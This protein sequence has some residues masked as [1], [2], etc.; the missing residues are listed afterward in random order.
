MF[1]CRSRAASLLWT[2]LLSGHC[3]ASIRLARYQTGTLV[4]RF[5]WSSGLI[6]RG[7]KNSMLKTPKPVFALLLLLVFAF[8]SAS[9]QDW[10]HTGT[11]RGAPIKLAVPD[12]K[13]AS[14]DPQT[15]P[16][17]TVFNQTL[18]NDL[19][20]SGVFEMVS[21]SFYPLQTPGTPGELKVETWGNAPVDAAMVAFGNLGVANGKVN[22]QGWLFDAKNAGAPQ[23]LGKQYQEN[24][25]PDYAR[26]IAHKFADEIIFRLGGGINGIAES[27]LYFISSRSGHKEVWQMDYDGAAQSQLTHLSSI[28][29]LSP[30]VSPDNTR[31][32]FSSFAKR[33]LELMMYSIELGRIVSFPTYNGTNISP[34]WAPDGSKIAFSS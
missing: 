7:R 13:A 9:A 26:L 3:S 20:N 2:S 12:F 27:K 11:N 15:A 16:L 4:A 19:D 10:V 22:V 14:G 23:I 25:T 17:N 18:W 24:A 21:K 5:R 30:R 29:S 34:A 1:G 8:M 31:I 28:A 32:I 33:G 6:I